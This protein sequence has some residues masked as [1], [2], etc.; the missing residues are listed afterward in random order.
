ML[1]STFA[2]HDTENLTLVTSHPVAGWMGIR[3]R[4]TE[5]KH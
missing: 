2:G 1:R 4:E 3:K 5:R